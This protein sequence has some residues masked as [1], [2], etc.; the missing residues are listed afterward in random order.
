MKVNLTDEKIKEI[1]EEANATFLV[2]G[3]RP[4]DEGAQIGRDYL[5]GKITQEEAI[6][7]ISELSKSIQK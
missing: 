5:E 1:I 6:K 4:V 7:R 2:E 3:L